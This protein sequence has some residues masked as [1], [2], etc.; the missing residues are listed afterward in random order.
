MCFIV[1]C[2]KYVI[3][4]WTV[5][6]SCNYIIT[7]SNSRNGDAMLIVTTQAFEPG[8]GIG[9]HTFFCIR[10]TMLISA[11]VRQYET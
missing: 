1:L 4:W 8:R 3:R 2:S 10:V 9:F 6:Y 5:M 7:L 11:T